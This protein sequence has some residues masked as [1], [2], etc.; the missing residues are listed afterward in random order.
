V[1]FG[2]GHLVAPFSFGG[3]EFLAEN[4]T[5]SGPIVPF[6]LT[7]GL[8]GFSFANFVETPNGFTA[9]GSFTSLA[10]PEPA[11]AGLFALAFLACRRR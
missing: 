1:T 3:G 9:T 8:I 4:V 7:D 10:A 2:S 11:S 6:P 5:F